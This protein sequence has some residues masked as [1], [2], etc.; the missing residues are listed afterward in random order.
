[1]VLALAGKLV[2]RTRPPD[3]T[4]GPL[5][6]DQ[7]ELANLPDHVRADIGLP[8]RERKPDHILTARAMQR[9]I[10]HF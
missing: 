10:F 4:A 6:P 1:V 9:D 5:D 8:A 3:S 2:K 7:P